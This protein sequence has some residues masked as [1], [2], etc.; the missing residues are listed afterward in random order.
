VNLTN[1]AWFGMTGAPYQHLCMTVFRA[2][3]NRIPMIRAANTGLSAYIKP[4]GEIIAQSKLFHEVVLQGSLEL[5]QPP[6]TFYARFGDLF[7]FISIVLALIGMIFFFLFN[8]RP[9]A[10]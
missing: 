9:Q 6:L 5:T 1:D 10:I 7:A 2:I 8:K 3:E 4:R